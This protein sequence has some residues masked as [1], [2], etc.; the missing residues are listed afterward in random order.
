MRKALICPAKSRQLCPTLCDPMDGR[1][2]GSAVPGILQARTLEWVAISLNEV[3]QSCLTLHD[4]MDCGP[5]GSSV[6]GI[7]QA[8]VLEWGAIA[9]SVWFVVITNFMVLIT[10]TVANIK[11]PVESHWTWSWE[12]RWKI[13]RSHKP[14][15]AAFSILLGMYQV[16]MKGEEK[17]TKINSKL[18]GLNVFI[19]ICR[20]Y[21]K[22]EDDFVVQL[23]SRV[24]LFA[25]Q[26]TAAHQAHLSSPISWSLFKFLFIESVILI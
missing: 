26:W 3:A 6:H 16:Q 8:R 5:P 13:S 10:T 20:V 9:F 17:V 1:P 21:Q 24:E 7:F 22:D 12:D 15:W 19:D 23:L 14:V 4:P 11:L 25:T 2:P 18:S